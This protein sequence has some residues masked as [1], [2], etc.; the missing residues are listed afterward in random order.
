MTTPHISVIIPVHN[1]QDTL[2]DQLDAV[3]VSQATAPPSEIVV[4]DNRSN[5][6]SI[7][8]AKQWAAQH[9]EANLRI[10]DASGRAG[11]PHARNIGLAESRGALV[12]FCDADDRVGPQW[13]SGLCRALRHRSYATGPIDTSQLNPAWIADVRGTSVTGRSTMYNL[14]PFAHGCNMGFHRDVLDA[15]GGFDER[16]LAG[17][18]LD[19]ALRFWNANVEMGYDEDAVVHYRLRQSLRST[20]DQGHFYGRFRIPIRNRIVNRIDD[21]LYDLGDPGWPRRVGWLVKHAPRVLLSKKVRARWVWVLGQLYGEWRGERD[22]YTIDLTAVERTGPSELPMRN[23]N[24]WE[25][26]S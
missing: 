3:R 12:A 17:C 18:D 15:M 5:D 7:A 20:F 1:A 9:R 8:L 16:Y 4:V 25:A 10:V 26:D 6:G 24:E 14:V 21:G 2:L 23:I 22:P 11:E 13:L 19:I